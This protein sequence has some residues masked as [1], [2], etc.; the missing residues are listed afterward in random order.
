[1][2]MRHVVPDA[3]ARQPWRVIVPLTL[4]VMFGSTVLYSAAGGS[5]KPWALS[6]FM[7]YLV[8]LGMALVLSFARR[9]YFKALAYPLYGLI[10][11]LLVL[12]ELIG[13]IGGGSQRWLNLGIVRFQPSEIKQ[14]CICQL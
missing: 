4:L 3:I 13:G 7:R 9:E 6:H 10:M 11:V 2:S 12:V 5:L 1:M 8:F 14:S